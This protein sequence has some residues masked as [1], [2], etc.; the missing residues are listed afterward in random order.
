MRQFPTST[1]TALIDDHPGLG[2]DLSQSYGRPLRVAE[3][4]DESVLAQ[5]LGYATSAGRHRL[6]ELIGSRLG[7]PAEQVLVTTGAA[8]AIFLTALLCGDGGEVVVHRPCFPPTHDAFF[9]IGARVVT[10]HARFE[11]GYR[12][13]VD[14]LASRL[15][16]S[17]RLVVLTTP[18]NPSGVLVT[19]A[20]VTAVVDAMRTTCPRALLLVD[21]TYAEATYGDDRPA[22]SCAGL[23]P[24]VLSCGSL[25]K[26]H[27]APGLR[28]GWLTVPDPD[29][30][31]RL[32]LAKFHTQLGCGNLDEYLAE[33]LLERR[34]AVLGPRSQALADGLAAV[35]DWAGRHTEHV[36]WQRPQAG[37]LCCFR[38]RPDVFDLDR[39]ERFHRALA[40]RRAR[41]ARGE[42]FGDSR[43]V[44]RVGFAYDPPDVLAAGL[45]AVAG[46]LA[47]AAA[48]RR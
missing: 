24:T 31:D 33:R 21:E 23:A 8:S 15:S 4:G 12:L 3:L 43:H 10:S 47:E 41:V 18:Q 42:W 39:V 11:D 46:A 32:R 48:A 1:I 38:L 2:V 5:P 45:D 13:D 34:D 16:A 30:R 25:S 44:F 20:E 36:E 19:R 40:E 29:L 35:A 28:I 17:T 6:R 37:A 9:G 22:E 7:V 14:H 27:G 26:A